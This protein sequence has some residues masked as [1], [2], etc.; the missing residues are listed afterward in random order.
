M[1]MGKNEIFPKVLIIAISRINKQDYFN[2]G[3]L[4]RNLFSNWPREKLAQIYSSGDNGDPGFCAR[5]YRLG[6]S[7]RVLGRLF[8]SLKN[9]AIESESDHN[10]FQIESHSTI[11]NAMQKGNIIRSILVDSGIYE[12]FFK[13]ILSKKMQ[14]WICEFQPDLILA[15]GYNLTFAWL[16]LMIHKT[17]KIPIAFFCSDDWPSYLY[18]KSNLIPFCLTRR[19]HAIVAKSASKLIQS[20]KIVFA[21]GDAMAREYSIRYGKKWITLLHTDDPSRF[22]EAIPKRIYSTKVKSILTLGSFN[23]FRW[24]L[25]IDLNECCRRL[26]L[27]GFCVRVAVMAL[28]IDPVGQK[29]LNKLEYI[30][31]LPDPGNDELPSYL[32][33][34]DLLMILE[35]FDEK[36]VDD[37]KLSVSSKA[38][39]FMFSKRPIIVYAHER[40]G[41]SCYANQYGWA[42]TVMSRDI[43]LLTET[44]KEVLS[45]D[46]LAYE[47]TARSFSVAISR[48]SRAIMQNRFLSA[49]LKETD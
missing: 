40:T 38:H 17:L 42:K 34:A 15:Q 29:K 32:K 5:Y 14:A 19:I 49:I 7:D 46:A 27:E 35:S 11:G 47:M 30:D 23:E 45:N 1:N 25:L 4:L 21:F 39:L 36:Y 6:P 28:N 44:V 2:N 26:S 12:F 13:P 16:P 8:Y 37:I 18:L 43:D 41:V 31:I 22:L 24:P 20:S 33:G 3:M 9:E 48:H 10:G